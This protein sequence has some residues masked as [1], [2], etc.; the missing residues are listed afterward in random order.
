MFW[1][2]SKSLYVIF[3]EKDNSQ[4]HS[5]CKPWNSYSPPLHG[6]LAFPRT[7]VH[8]HDTY[9]PVPPTRSALV[10]RRSPNSSS[11]CKETS[12]LGK[13][14]VVFDP[15]RFIVPHWHISN[16][17]ANCDPAMKVVAYAELVIFLRVL[18]GAITFRNSLL[19]PILFAH[20]LKQWYY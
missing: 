18:L 5:D 3:F 2:T 11:S 8:T 4:T 9:Q 1:F 16:T 6:F 7:H 14:S 17:T 20:F 12:S 15:F 19:S 10:C 13:L